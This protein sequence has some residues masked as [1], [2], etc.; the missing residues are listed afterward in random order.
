MN[1]KKEILKFFANIFFIFLWV[2]I[3]WKVNGTVFL[4]LSHRSTLTVSKILSY[5]GVLNLI[6]E[7]TFLFLNLILFFIFLHFGFLI[8]D[9]LENLFEK[10][11][12]G[13]KWYKAIWNIN[14]KKMVITLI[15]AFLNVLPI[16]IVAIT[17]GNTVDYFEVFIVSYL[18]FLN[19]FLPIPVIYSILKEINFK[20]GMKKYFYF[21]FYM[22]LPSNIL[23]FI[24]GLFLLVCSLYITLELSAPFHRENL[25][26]VLYAVGSVTLLFVVLIPVYLL[27]WLLLN[28]GKKIILLRGKDKSEAVNNS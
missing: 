10:G 9:L 4:V 21:F 28:F 1:K 13:D 2:V 8:S 23:T 24:I 19:G 6:K 16:T 18:I 11:S 22:F 14:F 12:L 17:R 5:E 7:G 25:D 3:C 15:F 27:W 20:I 26:V